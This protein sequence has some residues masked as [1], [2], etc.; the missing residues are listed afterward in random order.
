MKSI[1]YQ[2]KSQINQ[3][4][5]K[6]C[7]SLLWFL[8]IGGF[9][10][11]CFSYYGRGYMQIRSAADEFLL[12]S[13]SSRAFTMVFTLIFPLIAAT[14]C[15][16][17]RKKNEKNGDGLF[18]LL[19]MSKKKYILGNATAV[20]MITGLSILLVL[21]VN[22]LL[23]IIA[24]P[25]NGYDNRFAM[26]QY[27]M[28]AGYDSTVLLDFWQIQNPYI[29]NL[30]YSV[31][32]SVLG[33]GMALLAYGI[34]FVKK[35]EKMKSIQISIII[36]AL[37]ALMMVAGQLLDI[38]VLSYLSFVET[39][40]YTNLLNYFIFIIVVYGAGIALSI[41]GMKNYEYI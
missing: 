23:C 36:F 13:T 32:I 20:V 22:Q 6:I 12:V 18:S 30:L 16:G 2:I 31:M 38:P 40:H 27:M 29:Y 9:I 24:F 28:A 3:R 19:R 14:L 15:A 26:P 34:C 41:K 4:E 39:E 11:S 17:Y 25:I 10:V 33:G 37:F 21:V 7:F 5:Y 8:S 1:M 35:I